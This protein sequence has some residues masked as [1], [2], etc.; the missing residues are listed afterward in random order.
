M[1]KFKDVGEPAI[2]LLEE[3]AEAQ[4][5]IAKKLRFNGDWNEIAP[6]KEITRFE[7]LEAEMQDVFYQWE[8]L[9]QQ[10]SSQ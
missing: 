5:V 7:E 8:R 9:K 4:Q 2:T 3:M 10:I 1:G 6:G